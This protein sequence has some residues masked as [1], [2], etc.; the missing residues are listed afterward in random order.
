MLMCMHSYCALHAV[1]EPGSCPSSNCKDR[2]C[3]SACLLANMHPFDI[4]TSGNVQVTRQL[5]QPYWTQWRAD[6]QTLLAGLP[7]ALA[8]GSPGDDLLG[9]KLAFERWLLELK[10]CLR[11]LSA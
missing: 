3:M 1:H 10:V 8:T 11:G 2:A 4:C 7:G 6:T 5:F 9:L